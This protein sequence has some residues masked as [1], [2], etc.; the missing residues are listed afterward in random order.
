MNVSFALLSLNPSA[1]DSPQY[2][3]YKRLYWSQSRYERGDE[4]EPNLPVLS[5]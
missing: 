3:F 5:D 1:V 2:R 4:G